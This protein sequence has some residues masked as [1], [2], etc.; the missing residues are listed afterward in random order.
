MTTRPPVQA[1]RHLHP[2][3]PH[4]ACFAHSRSQAEI[5]LHPLGLTP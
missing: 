1:P 2:R 3:V 4:F 5:E